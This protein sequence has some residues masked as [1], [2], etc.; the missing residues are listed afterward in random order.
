MNCAVSLHN[1]SKKFYIPHEKRTTLKEHFI[2]IFNKTKYESFHAL[3]NI[4]FNVKKGEF[5][6]IIGANGSGKSTLLKII[7]GIYNPSEGKVTVNGKISPFLELGVGFDPELSGTENV[8]LNGAVLGLSKKQIDK[9]YQAI[10]E[11]AE[12]ERFMDM[13]VKNYSSG[14]FVRL[15]FSVAIQADADI[16]IM[17]EVFAVGDASFQQKCFEVLRRLKELNK[18]IIFVSHDINTMRSFCNRILYLKNGQMHMIGDPNEAIDQYLYTDKA[19]KTPIVS[20][21]VEKENEKVKITEITKVEFIDK[22]GY[23]NHTFFSE[24]PIIIRIHYFASIHIKNPIFGVQLMSENNECLFGTNTSISRFPIKE[25]SG[26]GFIDFKIEKLHIT[27]GKVMV[28]IAIRQENDDVHF[29][30]K[31]KAYNFN[32]IRNNNNIGN[33]SLNISFELNTTN[34]NNNQ[35]LLKQKIE[36]GFFLQHVNPKYFNMFD[37]TWDVLFLIDACRYDLFAKNNNL[38]NGKLTKKISIASCTPEWAKKSMVNHDLSQIIYISANPFISRAYLIEKEKMDI[39]FF[40]LEELWDIDWDKKLKTV[41][42]KKV[43][44]LALKLHKKYPDKK[45]FIHYIQ[46][47]HPFIGENGLTESGWEDSRNNLLGKI[48]NNNK[49][50]NIYDQLKEGKVTKEQVW[51]AYQ[52]NFDLILKEIKNN[53]IHFKGKKIISSDHGDCFGEYGIYAHPGGT[54]V[55]ELIEVPWFEIKE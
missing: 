16:L 9:K 4:S 18:T 15:A 34:I 29:D 30:W 42:P 6:G 19:E 43:T 10:V 1:V 40:L 2:H 47:H 11:F 25:I 31:D 20:T 51:K 14:M 3:N 35:E 38:I 21:A 53:L 28:T 13:K 33:I 26:H 8:Y 23:S 46:P 37:E 52:G 39:N 32:V 50:L 22:F 54:Y 36:E 5:L 24:D 12:M 49:E 7:A 27:F 55:P 44:T 45:L 41:L 17:D 48:N